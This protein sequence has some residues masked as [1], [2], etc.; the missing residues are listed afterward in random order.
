MHTRRALVAILIAIG[1]LAG[2]GSDDAA[3]EVGTGADDGVTDTSTTTE[4]DMADR[5]TSTSGGASTGGA[6]VAVDDLAARLG[7]D[8]GDVVTVSVDAVTWSDSSLGCPRKGFMYQQ[9][10]TEGTRI[11]LEVDGKRYHYHSGGTGDP[12]LCETPQEPLSVG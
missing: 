6:Q 2:C 3:T 7:V 12:F 8:P 9:V 11:I 5:T 4:A 1:L 10:V